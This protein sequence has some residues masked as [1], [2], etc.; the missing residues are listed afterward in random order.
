M[1]VTEIKTKFPLS[2]DD[3]KTVITNPEVNIFADYSQ[4]LIKDRALLIYLGNINVANVFFEKQSCEEKGFYDLVDSYITFKSGIDLVN[5][6]YSMVQILFAIKGISLS[7]LE[8][9]TVDHFSLIS[10]EG[11]R[12]YLADEKRLDNVLKLML[13]VDN[14]PTFMYTCSKEFRDG[15]IAPEDTFPVIDDLDF[16][17][18][19]FTGL[20]KLPLFY[21]HYFSSLAVE[22]PFYF[23]QQFDE[24][25]YN[26]KN[27]FAETFQSC[28][29]LYSA[30]NMVLSEKITPESM[31]KVNQEIDALM[32]A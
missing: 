29:E 9:K 12:D 13:L 21:M 26:G 5:L 22:H 7:E 3:L 2:M 31:Q 30:M 32:N 11:V 1:I 4:G 20:L 28:P 16:T 27:L 15:E 6:K 23:K 14:F 17:G 24:F 18:F 25:F 10:Q 19:T 8:Q